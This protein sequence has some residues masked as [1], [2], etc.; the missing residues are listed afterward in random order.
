LAWD[1]KQTGSNPLLFPE[2]PR[3][4]SV[5]TDRECYRAKI[6]ALVQIQV[7]PLADKGDKPLR[8]SQAPAWQANG[9]AKDVLVEGQYR[10]A[11]AKGEC[12]N[13]KTAVLI[14]GKGAGNIFYLCQAEKCDVHNRVTRY[15]PTPQEQAQR[16]KEALAKRVEKLSRVRI[17]EAIRKKLPDALSRPDL[18]MV[19]LDYFRRLGHDNHRRL[20]KLYAWEEKKSK[21]SWGG[22]TVDYEKIAATAVRAMKAANLHR[23]LVVCALVSDLCCPGYNPRQ[24]LEKDSNLAR[25]AVRY[26]VDFA[27]ITA[28][29]RAG[30]SGKIGG[31]GEASNDNRSRNRI[32]P[33]RK[34]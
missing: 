11:K 13:T 2:I 3:R 16:K 34:E 29:V 23:F 30:L 20:S 15:Q 6:E 24:L 33:R 10:R 5:C 7:K 25:T 14:D 19:A 28:A 32:A 1:L 4:A 12:P 27:K 18:E 22:E 21:A 8:V 26:K 9:H 31:R 17:L